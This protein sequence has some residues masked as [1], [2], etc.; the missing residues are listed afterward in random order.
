MSTMIAES[1]ALPITHA[2]GVTANPI[3][4][5]AE[6]AH[7]A[8]QTALAPTAAARAPDVLATLWADLDAHS[9]QMQEQARAAA[10]QSRQRFD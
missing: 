2:S 9:R 6:S 3:P 5:P 4:Q 1:A 7:A 10:M 8:G